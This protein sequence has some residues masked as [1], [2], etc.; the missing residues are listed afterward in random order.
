MATKIEYA[1]GAA[2]LFIYHL[3]REGFDRGMIASFGNDYR[4]EQGFTSTESYLHAALTSSRLSPSEIKRK[5][6]GTRLYDS[7]EDVINEF[8]RNGRRD[9]PWLLTVITDGKD[10]YDYG[11]YKNNPY[12]IGRFIATRFNH[13]PSNFI[14]VIGVG[15]GDEIDKNA[16]SIMAD[17]GNFLAMTIR[18]FP[19]LEAIFLRIAINVSSQLVGRRI[20]VGNLSWE[21]VAHL[22]RVSQIA[23]DYAF[24]IDRSGSM[25]GPG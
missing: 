2:R 7:I 12:G 21:E 1:L 14:F 19:L 11:K 8:W 9:R 22:R 13:E 25:S 3:H 18:A 4:V 15:E 10:Y 17:A 20:E 16:L 24:L 6:E 23:L 5:N